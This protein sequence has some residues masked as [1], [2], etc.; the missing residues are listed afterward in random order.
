VSVKSLALGFA[1]GNLL[2]TPVDLFVTRSRPIAVIDFSVGALTLAYYWYRRRKDRKKAG[3]AI[4]AKS[5]ALLAAIAGR[6]R[7]TLQ[8]RPGLQPVPVG[9]S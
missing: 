9:A 7:E 2:L 4:G 3:G 8:S 5:A 1:V 6:M